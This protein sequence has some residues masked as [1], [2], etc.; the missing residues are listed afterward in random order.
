MRPVSGPDRDTNSTQS[1]TP[2]AIGSKTGRRW[3]VALVVGVGTLLS[4]M[5]ASTVTLALPELG[6]ELGISIDTAGWVMEAFL[7]AV[8][9]LLLPAGRGS[10]VLGHGKVYLAGFVVFGLAS[11]A[12]GLAASF[13]W[14]I[15]FRVVQGVGGAL[16]MA[17][18][19]ALLTT[20]FPATER[21]K[22][23]GIVSTAT[24]TGLT[25]GPPLGGVMVSTLGWRWVFFLNVP[26]AALILGMG[27]AFLPRGTKR[28]APPPDVAGTVSLAVGLPLLLVAIIEGPTWGWLA[29][30]TLALGLG[31]AAVLAAFVAIEARARSPLLAPSLFA[32]PAFSGAALSAMANYVSLFVPI[33]LMPYYLREGLGLRPIEVGLLLTAQPLVM[34]IVA[35]PAGWLSDRIGTTGL[36]TAGMALLAAGLVGLAT[37]GAE[38]HVA[39]VGAWLGLMGLGTGI[40][41]SPNSS[42]LMGAAP[43]DRQGVAGGVLAVARNLGMMAGVATAM[44]VFT[45]AGGTTGREWTAGEFSALRWALHVGAAVA[46]LGAAAAALRGATRRREA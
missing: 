1:S 36:A 40:F 45:V 3:L 20:S 6:R 38:S 7:V 27:A 26:T 42:A 8:T 13:G 18:A 2:D 37:I 19:P 17:T 46:V 28:K 23:L 12:C 41:I 9:V 34:A 21:G 33:M 11:L 10:D 43:P 24:Y 35:S 4:A 16:I 39:T 25:I 31:G 30:G 5:A 32:S 15:A 29:P 44:T 14:L 22:A